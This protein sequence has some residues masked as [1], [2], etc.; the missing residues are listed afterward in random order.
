MLTVSVYFLGPAITRLMKSAK[1]KGET[2]GRGWNMRG[3]SLTRNVGGFR[4]AASRS[5]DG[6]TYSLNM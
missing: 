2:E 5:K 3:R 1:E 4:G 6:S